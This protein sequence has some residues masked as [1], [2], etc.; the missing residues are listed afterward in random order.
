MGAHAEKFERRALCPCSSFQANRR[1]YTHILEASLL[2]PYYCQLIS[3]H[4][5]TY[6]V[7]GVKE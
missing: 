1:E 2:P 6:I 4:H 7:T 3:H 5:Y